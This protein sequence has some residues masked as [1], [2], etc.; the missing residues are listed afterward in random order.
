MRDYYLQKWYTRVVSRA[1][2]R[3][4][5]LGKIKKNQGKIKKNSKNY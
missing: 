2:E 4:K 1:A 3:L 5:T